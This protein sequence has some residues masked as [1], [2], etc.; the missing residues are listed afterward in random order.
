MRVQ[1]LSIQEVP[2]LLSHLEKVPIRDALIIRLML[3]CGLR[4][5]E[6]SG[7]RVENV[8]RA[9]FVHPCVNLP[10]SS[11]KGHVAR[12]VDMS[13]PLRDL[14]KRHIDDEQKK[15]RCM[16]PDAWLVTGQFQRG[17]LRVSGIERLTAKISQ[18]ALG[19]TV[20]PHLLRHTYAT[21]LLKFTNIRVVQA[22]LGH[23][24][25]N[26]TEIYLH[27]TSED[28]RLAVNQAFGG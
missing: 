28:S 17:R 7:L 10:R 11:T 3:Q 4:A 14:V 22:L 13:E 5:G 20:H 16:T 8:W 21:I 25:I 27:P 6:V 15:G 2:V 12:H 24:K 26:T 23:A 18:A 1:I 9:G 19:R